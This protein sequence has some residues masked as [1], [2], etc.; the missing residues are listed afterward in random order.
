MTRRLVCFAIGNTDDKLGQASW[1]AFLSE[2]HAAVDMA[3]VDG[4]HIQFA[5]YSA[6]GAP[7]QNALWAIEIPTGEEGPGIEA[8]LRV[9]L[10][11]LAGRYRQDSI[12]WWTTE[13][14]EFLEP[15]R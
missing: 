4:A 14:V 2:V 7:W 6:P 13:K 3:T 10:T 11:G 15:A 8:T 5:G 1:S 9:A 12:A